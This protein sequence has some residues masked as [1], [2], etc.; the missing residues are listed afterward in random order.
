MRERSSGAGTVTAVARRPAGRRADPPDWQDAGRADAT[1]LLDEGVEAGRDLIDPLQPAY[2]DALVDGLAAGLGN[3]RG[4]MRNVLDGSGRIAR[5]LTVAPEHGFIELIQNADD[6][7]AHCVRFAVSEDQREL[8]VV[9]DGARVL[10]AN[11]LAMTLALVS[12]KPDDSEATGKFGIGLKTVTRLAASFE[13]HS[14]PYHFRVTD[15]HLERVRA[16]P[17][18]PPL[19]TAAKPETLIALK[20]R[21]SYPADGLARWFEQLA[22]DALLFMRSV[23]RLELRDSAGALLDTHELK[24]SRS[25]K[26][27]LTLDS[28]QA[29]AEELELRHEKTGTKWW[30]L[31]TRLDTAPGLHRADKATPARSPFAVAYCSA[32]G[33]GRLFAGLPLAVGG[34]LPFHLNALFDTD[35]PRTDLLQEQWNEWILNRLTELCCAGVGRRLATDTATGWYAVPLANE[36]QGVHSEWLRDQLEGLVTAVQERARSASVQTADGL[37]ALDEV[38]PEVA[39][40]EPLLSDADVRRVSGQPTIERTQ[41]DET[42][43]WREVL[44]ELDETPF[45]AVADALGMLAWEDLSQSGDW[46]VGLIDAAVS[47]GAGALARKARCLLLAD[48]T[49]ITPLAARGEGLLLGSDE[50]DAG[51]LADRLELRRPLDPAFLAAQ[52]AADRVRAWLKDTVGI[53]TETHDAEA[54]E[55][56][57]NRDPESP[58]YLDDQSLLLLRD[59]LRRVRGQRGR[60]F[61][62]AIGERILVDGQTYERGRVDVQ[63]RPSEAYLPSAIDTGQQTWAKAAADTKGLL[64]VHPRYARVLGPRRQSAARKLDSPEDARR[65]RA[66][67]LSERSGVQSFFHDLGAETAPRLE[68]RGYDMWRRNARVATMLRYRQLLLTQR[69]AFAPNDRMAGLQDDFLSPDLDAVLADIARAKVE[70]GRRR[71]LALL[72]SLTRAWPR[73]YA[74]HEEAIVVEATRSTTYPLGRLPATWVARAAETAWMTNERRH[75]KAPR[76]LAIRTVAFEAIFG[77]APK[78]YAYGLDSYDID[79]HAVRAFRFQREARGSTLL[80]RLEELRD[81]E[82]AGKAIDADS[83]QRCYQALSHAAPPPDARGR[84]LDDVTIT[85]VRERFRRRSASATGLVRSTGGWKAPTDVLLGRAIFK[86]RR[87][88]V[89]DDA[90]ALWR[91]LGMRHPT[92]ADCLRILAELAEEGEPGRETTAIL[93]DTYRYLGRMAAAGEADGRALQ[94]APLWTGR[95]WTTDRPVYAVNDP[96]LQVTLGERVAVWRP[97][98]RLTELLALIP[99]FKLTLLDDATFRPLGINT[100]ALA[101]GSRIQSRFRTAAAHLREWLALNDAELHEDLS[102]LPGLE[103]ARVAVNA[104]LHVE[105]PLPGAVTETVPRQAHVHNGDDGMLFVFAIASYV[106][107]SDIMGRLL[108]QLLDSDERAQVVLAHAWLKA[109]ELTDSDSAL[110]G[111]QLAAASA[112]TPGTKPTASKSNV[113]T[114]SPTHAT[115]KAPK[116]APAKDTTPPR[117]LQKLDDIQVKVDWNETTPEPDGDAGS[118]NGVPPDKP[119]AAPTPGAKTS[120]TKPAA[121]AVSWT[122]E[123]KET[124]GLHVLFREMSRLYGRTLT[125]IRRQH[126]VGADAIDQDGRYYE[127]K[128]HTG[129]M[130]DAVRLEPSEFRRAQDEQENFILAVVAGLEE[131]T[132]TQLK[133]IAD[134][135]R[136]LT[137]QPNVEMVVSGLITAAWSPADDDQ[138][139]EPESAAAATSP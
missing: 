20:L 131:G 92:P 116:P 28:G 119:L 139:A 111:V 54:L 31:T 17:T 120:P 121:G 69:D 4:W 2:A 113:E 117:K 123:E 85:E 83:V 79:A 66:A 81:T 59:A 3:P 122:A 67:A 70:D 128:A 37:V 48:G 108:G 45:L 75:R 87:S 60:D 132:E 35:A 40:L 104:K 57:A 77:D 62:H 129:E 100:G 43:R 99:V 46:Y 36:V 82:L 96:A 6:V 30:R 1:K 61:A 7:K 38:R 27:E 8:W 107:D 101:A 93:I 136:R 25:R 74:Q 18:Q 78:L 94:R 24:R 71:A 22:P 137:W 39:E 86:T 56:L 135:L 68:A 97:P 110:A 90:P 13:V 50:T 65:R 47:A 12:T 103:T 21:D 95:R 118:S 80:T 32:P 109:L 19:Y 16:R 127:L 26:V 64:W 76:D 130:P 91:L 9:H 49:R 51:A 125:D 41:R 133:L 112:G 29:E 72:R 63:V 55:A 115:G 15:Q 84:R 89:D 52:P 11:V 134:P 5:S 102:A 58:L 14:F 138:P 114:K 106:D 23:R 42:G 124:L 10:G 34:S 44:A 88:F 126:N 105:I 33:T 98:L 73:L 53:R